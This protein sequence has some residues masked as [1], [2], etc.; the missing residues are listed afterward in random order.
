M[1]RLQRLGLRQNKKGLRKAYLTN[2]F[3]I[4]VFP[5]TIK[6]LFIL[7]EQA[8]VDK[9]LYN[10]LAWCCGRSHLIE[11][12]RQEVGNK[13]DVLLRHLRQCV[14]IQV[15]NILINSTPLDP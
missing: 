8:L 15:I 2:S 3:Y 11:M 6:E 7:P 5:L 9:R 1:A 14:E 13:G 10:N 4:E 12:L